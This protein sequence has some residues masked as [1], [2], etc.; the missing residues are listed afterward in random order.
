ME[1]LPDAWYAPLVLPFIPEIRDILT[2]ETV[3]SPPG[4]CCQQLEEVHHV[5]D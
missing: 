4:S 1:I 3:P 5:L 2:M